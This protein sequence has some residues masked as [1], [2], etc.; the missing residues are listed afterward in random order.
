[1]KLLRTPDERFEN[2]P[3]Y[4]FKP[5]YVESDGVRIHYVDEGSRDAENVLLMHGEP[6]WSYL[7]R[8]MIPLV[9]DAGYRA[10][11]P[12]L[13]GFGRSDKP[14]EM[15]DHTYRKHIDWM[16]GLIIKVDLENITLFCQDWGALIG[17]RLAV[18]DDIT[19]RFARI[20]LSNGGLP[21]SKAMKNAEAFMQWREFSQT[22]P[23]INVGR[24]VQGGTSSK[25]S[26][27]V[28]LAYD[29]PFPEDSYKA[30]VR[31]LPALVPIT[32]DDPEDKPNMQAFEKY[33]K[34]TKPF[35]TCFSDSDPITRGGDKLFQK[36]VPGAK[37]QQ[38]VT[39]SGSGHFVQEDKGEEL[40]HLIIKFIKENPL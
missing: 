22:T 27:E 18:E 21:V 19:D 37:S 8:R 6:T 34:W 24:L 10:V 15:S 5:N 30:G 26:K 29:A 17:L 11:A 4:P 3:G 13:V 1:M 38:H 28:K 16:K 23:K 9:V 14:T 36:H 32:P 20:V 35:L 31:V 2:L 12:D 39:I 25:I 40:A 7:Y 33:K